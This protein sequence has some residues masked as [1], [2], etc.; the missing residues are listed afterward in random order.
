MEAKIE[1]KNVDIK[2]VTL[3]LEL[4]GEVIDKVRKG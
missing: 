4:D 3:P 2:D 1:N